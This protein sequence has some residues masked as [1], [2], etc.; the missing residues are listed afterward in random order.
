MPGPGASD[1]KLSS[2]LLNKNTSL[3]AEMNRTIIVEVAYCR[4]TYLGSL[5]ERRQLGRA[6]V[7]LTRDAFVLVKRASRRVVMIGGWKVLRQKANFHKTIQRQ[8][9]RSEFSR[10]KDR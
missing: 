3:Q 5:I 7:A 4:A 8:L 10:E 9:S 1:L 2:N 6:N